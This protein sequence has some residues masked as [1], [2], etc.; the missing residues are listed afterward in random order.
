MAADLWERSRLGSLP[1]ETA[2]YER[3]D[4]LVTSISGS[5]EPDPAGE[6]FAAF[7]L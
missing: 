6:H 2:N 7:D 1:G 5:A 3:G 4:K